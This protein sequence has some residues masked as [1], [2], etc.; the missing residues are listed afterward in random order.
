[1]RATAACAAWEE[2]PHG[3]TTGGHPVGCAISLE[4]IRI[5]TQEGVLDNIRSVGDVFQAGL[6]NL[7]DHPMVGEARG[8]GLMGALEMVADKRT[9]QS[10][11]GGLR[12]GERI[13]KEARERGFII[14]PLGA[15]IVLAPP[16]IST[17][18]QIEELLAVLK[19]VL[20][21]VYA[22]VGRKG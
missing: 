19:E 3:F 5:I 12:I 20:D 9:K 14:R 11:D 16:F 2:F 17:H 10:F 13:A 22:S 4:A 6:R 18:A 8:L 1:M 21:V 15:S 7:A